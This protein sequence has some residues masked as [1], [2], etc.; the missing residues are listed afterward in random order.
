M[1]DPPGVAQRPPSTPTT[2][3]SALQQSPSPHILQHNPTL[4]HLSLSNPASVTNSPAR[5]RFPSGQQSNMQQHTL[6]S[7]PTLRRGAGTPVR[8]YMTTAQPLSIPTS[9]RNYGQPY[10]CRQSLYAVCIDD[11]CKMQSAC[12]F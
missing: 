5:T 3:T 8:Q 6:F 11:K 9:A 1:F 12:Y 4:R 10:R 7:P 2:V